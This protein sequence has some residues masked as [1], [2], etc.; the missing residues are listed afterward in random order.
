METI[1]T[2][3]DQTFETQLAMNTKAK[4][5]AYAIRHA[6]FCNEFNWEPKNAFQQEIDEFDQYSWHCL[7]KHRGVRKYTGCIRLV[8]R[9]LNNPHQILPVEKYCLNG[10]NHQLINRIL[11]SGGR[12]GEISRLAILPEYRRKRLGTGS[13]THLDPANKC[14]VKLMPYISIGLYL[15]IIALASLLKLKGVVF[16]I[17]PGLCRRLREIGFSLTKVSEDIMHKGLRA[18]YYLSI[19]NFNVSDFKSIEVQQFHH[20]F[21]DKIRQQLA[22]NNHL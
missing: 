19:E 22:K 15:S 10:K 7:L 8:I 17:E 13:S 9:A 18:I 2:Q 5:A 1:T 12:V 3:F 4:K 16:L 6:V 20:I 21:H 14:A 11:C